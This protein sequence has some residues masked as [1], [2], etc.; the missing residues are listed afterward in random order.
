M[1]VGGGWCVCVCVCV[2]K[3]LWNL[4]VATVR[5]CLIMVFI[6]VFGH[7]CRWSRLFR[8]CFGVLVFVFVFVCVCFA[9]ELVC[10]FFAVGVVKIWC[11][12]FVV[13]VCCEAFVCVAVQASAFL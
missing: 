5:V 11:S 10:C 2:L 1:A 7:G 8:G 3:S 12:W 9:C 6:G 13:L 4:E